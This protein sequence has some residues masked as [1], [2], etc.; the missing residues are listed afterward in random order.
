MTLETVG[1][2]AMVEDPHLISPS[3]EDRD[4]RQQQQMVAAEEEV[5]NQASLIFFQPG[6]STVG[7]QQV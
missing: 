4:G 3:G 7:R 6:G 2:L 5:S 1:A